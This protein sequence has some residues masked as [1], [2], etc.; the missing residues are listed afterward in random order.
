MDDY[1]K[2]MF[3]LTEEEEVDLLEHFLLEERYESVLLEW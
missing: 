1:L 2:D 3:Y